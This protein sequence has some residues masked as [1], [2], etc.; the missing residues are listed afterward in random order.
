MKAKLYQA[1]TLSGA[2][3]RVRQLQKQLFSMA[4]T[5][6]QYRNDRKW[7]A[8]LAAEGPCFSNPLE[9]MAA[10]IRRDEILRVQCGLNP[11]GTPLNRDFNR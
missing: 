9:A 11:D 6:G 1:K 7:M 3:S 4:E 8:M 10:K 5:L 2:Q